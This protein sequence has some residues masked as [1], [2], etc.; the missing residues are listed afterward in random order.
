MGRFSSGQTSNSDAS[1][2]SAPKMHDANDVVDKRSNLISFPSR[3]SSNHEKTDILAPQTVPITGVDMK[4]TA[5]NPPVIGTGP[6]TIWTT[7]DISAEVNSS[8]PFN[9]SWPAPLD[10]VIVLDNVYALLPPP[11]NQN[12]VLFSD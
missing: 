11:P 3:E 10:I 8:E 12:R 5:V 4:Q 9:S 7:V 1:S 2:A 6:D